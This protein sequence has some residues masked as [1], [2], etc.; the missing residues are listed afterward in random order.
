MFGQDMNGILRML[1]AYCVHLQAGGAFFWD[2]AFVAENTGYAVG[3]V[4]KSASTAGRY[5]YNTTANNANN[6]DSVSTGWFA[7]SAFGSPTGVQTAAP[8]GSFTV[9]LTAGTG[10]LDVTPSAGSTLTNVTG[11]SDGQLLTITNLSASFSLTVDAGANFRMASDLGLLEK[12][13]ASFR[14]SAALALWVPVNG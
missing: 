13:S 4:L 5:W 3:A 8:S 1:S 14:Y 7:Y 10:F 6:P 2:A 12:N 11:G 9:A